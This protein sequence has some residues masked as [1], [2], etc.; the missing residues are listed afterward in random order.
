MKRCSLLFLVLLFLASFA[1]AERLLI[2]SDA[3]LTNVTLNDNAPRI[4]NLYVVHDMFG[5]TGIRF[6]VAPGA[7]FAGVWLGETTPFVKIGNSVSDVSVGY[8]LCLSGP[9]LILT[10]SYQLFGTSAACSGVQVAPAAGFPC[11]IIG[12]V[13]CAFVEMCVY[14][15]GAVHVNCAVPTE[16]TTWGKVKSLY[17][18]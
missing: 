5:G 13:G 10:I 16:P 8:G 17:R 18:D 11:V 15:L 1:H 2:Y 14:D 6:R 4:A 9:Y 12:S 3:A 7:G